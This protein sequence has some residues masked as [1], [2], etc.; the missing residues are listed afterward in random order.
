MVMKN[1][2]EYCIFLGHHGLHGKGIYFVFLTAKP[3]EEHKE[4][5][6]AG[7]GERGLGSYGNK[8]KGSGR[9]D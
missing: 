6:E 9:M 5:K 3:G 1:E 4:R 7:E 8:P 2:N